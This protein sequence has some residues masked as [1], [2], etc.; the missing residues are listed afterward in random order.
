MRNFFLSVIGFLCFA[1]ML[2]SCSYQIYY[3]QRL[4]IYA[5]DS[6]HQTKTIVRPFMQIVGAQI[7]VAHSLSNHFFISGVTQLNSSLF[8]LEKGNRVST[9]ALTGAFSANAGVG[10]FSSNKNYNGIELSFQMIGEHNQ[11]NY[12]YFPAYTFGTKP[13]IINDR[14]NY[15]LPSFQFAY[16][17]FPSGK[18]NFSLGC[19]FSY[20]LADEYKDGITLDNEANGFG[21]Y[22]QNIYLQPGFRIQ[23]TKI[24]DIKLEG[25]VITGVKTTALDDYYSSVMLSVMIDPQLLKRL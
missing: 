21:F 12:H 18:N 9:Q 5:F 19:R 22:F 6:S 23:L 10:Y 14:I 16:N 13:I 3:P 15:L 20:A 4:N 24:P 25:S 7:G 1:E 2:C 17:H 11:I 8:H